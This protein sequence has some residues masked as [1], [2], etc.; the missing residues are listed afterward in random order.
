M[1]ITEH[2]RLWLRAGLTGCDFAKKLSAIAGQVAIVAQMDVKLPPTEWLN[3]EFDVHANQD[4]AVIAV[5]PHIQ[6]ELALV[7]LLKGLSGGRWSIQPRKKRSPTGCALVGVD[8][9]TQNGDSSE[10]MGFAPFPSM[11]VTRRA[12]YVAL[13]TWPGG[14]SNPRRGIAPTPPARDKVVSFLDAR[15]E[16]D[17]AEYDKKWSET[18]ARVSG[19]MEV[20]PDDAS[21]YRR[22]AFVISAESAGQLRG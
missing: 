10:A 19:L 11:P 4:R 3:R 13:G 20:P 1:A 5:F 9:T 8:W 18:S 2:F 7:E 15:H 12:P 14:R 21:L 17:D 6:S 22:T 16:L